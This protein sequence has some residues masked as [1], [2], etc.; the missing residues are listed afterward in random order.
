MQRIFVEENGIY[1]IDL[2]AAVEAMDDL[3]A[4]Y[5][6]IGNFLSDVDFIAETNDAILLI[7]YKNTK[8][9]NAQNPDAFKEKVSNGELYDNVLKKYYG[10]VFYILACQKK[11]PINFVLII[12]SQFMDIVMRK[13]ALAAIKKRLP[14][15]LQK[16]PE[17]SVNLISDFKVLSIKEWNDQFSM[18]PLSARKS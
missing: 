2:S 4:K 18:F 12:E 11:K 1:Q 7:E 15:I 14:F 5:K 13:R 6:A 9:K 16:I 17:V 3:G 8:I 10:S